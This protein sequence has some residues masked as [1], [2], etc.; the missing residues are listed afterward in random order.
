MVRLQCPSAAEILA[1]REAARDLNGVIRS[2]VRG[3]YAKLDEGADVDSA[4]KQL[5]KIIKG[6]A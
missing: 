2:A 3:V 1:L 5:G 4:A 6:Q